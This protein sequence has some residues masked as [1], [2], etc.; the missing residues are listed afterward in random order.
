MQVI[1]NISLLFTEL[2]LLERIAAAKQAGFAGVEIQFPYT[3]DPHKLRAALTSQ[4][5]PLHLI[6]LPA[7]DLMQGGLGLAC[8]VSMRSEFAQALET[9]LEY[10]LILKPK[11]VNVLSGRVEQGQDVDAAM[12]WLAA[13][14][15][16]TARA[17]ARLHTTVT[18]EAIHPYDMPG[19]LLNTTAQQLQLLAE[20]RQENCLAQLD[21]YHMA[22][23]QIDPLQALEQLAGKIGHVQFADC[24]GRHEPGSGTLDFLAVRHKLQEVGYSGVWAA[25]YNP[26]N[27]TSNTLGWLQQP[28]FITE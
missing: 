26:S 22:R 12:S 1:A 18:C 28:A 10:A 19:F 21:L 5:M 9:A 2:P 16:D 23:Q 20:V 6:N 15:R 13:N 27:V 11:M 14:L 8:Q 17:F 25:E 24:P 4:H 3:E 7:G